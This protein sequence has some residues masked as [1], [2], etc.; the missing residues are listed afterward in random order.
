MSKTKWCF[1]FVLT[2]QNGCIN[3][4]VGVLFH[5]SRFEGF[6]RVTLFQVLQFLQWK[7][8]QFNIRLSFNTY[9]NIKFIQI[10]I[11][12]DIKHSKPQKTE[13]DACCSSNL[14]TH[15]YI[16]CVP[17]PILIRRIIMHIYIYIFKLSLYYTTYL[18]QDINTI[19]IIYKL[20]VIAWPL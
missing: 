8:K 14:Q 2:G 15:T 20:L 6:I 4:F 12:F 17:V 3:I 10:N 5:F 11:E 19:N 7:R 9:I 13:L 16:N 18:L 1:L